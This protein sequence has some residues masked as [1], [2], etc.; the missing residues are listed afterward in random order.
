M[1]RFLRYWWVLPVGLALLAAV[2]LAVGPTFRGSLQPASTV[3]EACAPKP[4]A[5]P[6]GFEIDIAELR[7]AAGT[8]SFQASFKNRTAPDLGTTS[9]RPTSPR[10]FQ[11]RLVDG[12]QLSPSFSGDCPDW[13]VLHVERGASAG[14]EKLCFQTP[15]AAGA[16]V[17]WG[18]DLGFLFDDVRIP[19]S[20]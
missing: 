6:K 18:P 3:S 14:P 15:T 16:F 17:V 2:G 7:S 8:T 9:F 5:A 12:R 13:G 20:A 11:L 4:C 10:D 19:L 1:A